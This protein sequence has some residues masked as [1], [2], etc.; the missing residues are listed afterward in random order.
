MKIENRLF[1]GK[2]D[3]TGH[4]YVIIINQTQ[5]DKFSDTEFRLKYILYIT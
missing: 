5:K 4:H 3:G 2:M 1:V